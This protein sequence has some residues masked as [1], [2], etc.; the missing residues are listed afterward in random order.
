MALPKVSRNYQILIFSAIIILAVVFFY[1]F[2]RQASVISFDLGGLNVQAPPATN[3]IDK[4][5]L[6]MNLNLFG[7]DKF[8]N[9]RSE[10]APSSS[11][12]S[13]KRDPF[14]PQ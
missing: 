10:V 4:A 6:N 14:V 9:L 12:Q 11:F 2:F 13:G 1:Y 7:T 5:E 8:I 3:I